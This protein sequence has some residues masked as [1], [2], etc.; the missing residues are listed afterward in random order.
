[1]SPFSTNFLF[2]NQELWCNYN[3]DGL[4]FVTVDER[5][6]HVTT[7]GTSALEAVFA[8]I[9]LASDDEVWIIT[10]S[11]NRYISGCVTRTVEKFCS[12]KRE[13]TG[14]T[15]A[16]LVNHEFGFIYEGIENLAYHDLPVIEDC[17]YSMYSA[18]RGIKAGTIGDYAIFSMA[19]MFPVQAGGLVVSNKN[20][21]F[22][23][24][25]DEKQL[26]YFKACFHHYHQEKEKIIADRLNVYSLMQEKF[27]KLGLEPRFVVREGEVPGAFLFK[28]P[29]WPLEEMKIFLQG[30]GV[31][32]S[33]F[34]GE[35]TFYLPCH[36]GI[37]SGHVDYLLT[38]INYFR[39]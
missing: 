18:R 25:C 1:M 19:K 7:S 34:Y 23:A 36:Q 37:T 30:Q 22:N 5:K 32:C 24:V 11:G 29:G 31:E 2:Q 14:K 39:K 15:K 27:R 26:T 4:P 3:D 12:W 17:A 6:M 9:G 16:I 13:K 21:S 20:S 35:E 33:V 38:L 28:A 8:R 10:T